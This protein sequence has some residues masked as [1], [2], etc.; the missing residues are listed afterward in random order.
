MLLFSINWTHTGTIFSFGSRSFYKPFTC[1]RRTMY[2]TVVKEFFLKTWQNPNGFP[3]IDG[4]LLGVTVLDLLQSTRLSYFIY[5]SKR[6]WH[7]F[8]IVFKKCL[9]VIRNKKLPN[10]RTKFAST[11]KKNCLKNN[12][13]F[14]KSLKGAANKSY[15][16]HPLVY[17]SVLQLYIY[18]VMKI[19]APFF[20]LYI[21]P[22]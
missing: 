5:P 2:L 10:T 11:E 16:H 7:K 21:N 15:Q 8:V 22:L 9:F 4:C 1:E 3:K 12:A 13:V 17:L 6:V 14:V 19:F 18:T 20:T